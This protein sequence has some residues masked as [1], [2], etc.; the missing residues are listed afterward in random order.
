[1]SLVSRFNASTHFI[2]VTANHI[3]FCPNFIV[4]Y[5]VL[6]KLQGQTCA[7]GISFGDPI[8]EYHCFSYRM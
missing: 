2:F 3:M 5:E 7:Q 6:T 4:T 1:M 8:K